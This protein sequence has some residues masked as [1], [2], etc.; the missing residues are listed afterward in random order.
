MFNLNQLNHLPHKTVPSPYY[1]LTL[2]LIK[3]YNITNKE[4]EC[5]K[6]KNIHIINDLSLATKAVTNKSKWKAVHNPIF[7]N[8]L[9]TFNYKLVHNIL[10]FQTKFCNFSL[11]K[12][13]SFCVFCNKGPDSAFHV[14]KSCEKLL[15]IWEFLDSLIRKPTSIAV[16]IVQHQLS[17]NYITPASLSQLEADMITPLITI[18]NH[19][20]WEARNTKIHQNTKINARSMVIQIKKAILQRHRLESQK[21]VQP[22]YLPSLQRL[23]ENL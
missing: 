12:A 9:K 18:T 13:K 23:R 4:L 21:I 3:K 20:I 22:S 6:I 7:P 16:L 14:F 2:D 10:P 15:M 8:Y 17:L 1:R 19:K 5:D 11:D